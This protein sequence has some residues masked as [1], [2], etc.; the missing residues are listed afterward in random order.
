MAAFTDD[1]VDLVPQLDGQVGVLL[2]Q[3]VLL[4]RH[5]LGLD[6]L[7]LEAIEF[8]NLAEVL[9]LDDTI[10]KLPMEQPS[11]LGKAQMCLILHVLR[12]EKVINLPLIHGGKSDPLRSMQPARVEL[13]WLNALPLDQ[14]LLLGL[15]MAYQPFGPLIGHAKKFGDD[16]YGDDGLSL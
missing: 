9:R 1:L 12:I 2:V 15:V 5:I 8:Q 4:L 14:E 13:R 7:K 3:L 16:S 11:S 6:L 10:R